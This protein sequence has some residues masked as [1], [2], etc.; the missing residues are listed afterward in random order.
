M[1]VDHNVSTMI[2][3]PLTK[4][5]ELHITAKVNA[6]K[7]WQFFLYL[8]VGKNCQCAIRNQ[9]THKIKAYG[10]K[11]TVLFLYRNESKIEQKRETSTKRLCQF[12]V[13]F[14]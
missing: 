1:I 4:Y 12:K 13:Y 8:N 11:K 9:R 3:L 7:E 6:I 14:K 2:L 5:V 10:K